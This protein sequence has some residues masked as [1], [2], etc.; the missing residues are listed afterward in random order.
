[1]VTI[2]DIRIDPVLDGLIRSN[3]RPSKPFP[4]PG[5]PLLEDQGG[6]VHPGGLVESTLGGFLVQS[7]D[8]VVLVDAGGGQAFTD[9]HHSPVID[10]DDETDPI[11]AAL[12]EH[13]L[14][15]EQAQRTVDALGQ[16]YIEQG[17]LPTS[18]AALGLWPEDVTDVVCT[19][20]HFDHIGWLSADGRP[21]FPNATVRCAGADLEYFLAGPDE[22]GFV[23]PLFGAISARERLAPVLDRIDTWESDGAICAGIDVRLAAGHTPG[24]SVVVVADGTSRALL[25]GDVVHCPLELMDDDFNLLV[26]HDQKLADQ[27]REAIARE[28]EDTDTVA[29]ASHFPGLRFGRLIAGQSQRRWTFSASSRLA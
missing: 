19:H 18:L 13:G 12:T 11:T 7:G 28:I 14:D 22:E 3:L 10:L 1:M 6:M 27:V 25:L 20:L 5:S 15:R 29:S 16:T 21:Y 26:D 24:S 4:P 23:L 9:G 2:G 17:S 8:R